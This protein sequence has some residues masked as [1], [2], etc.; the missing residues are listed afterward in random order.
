MKPEEKFLAE[1]IKNA[2][3]ANALGMHKFDPK[4]ETSHTQQFKYEDIQNMMLLKVSKS[5][6]A[7]AIM[8]AF[9]KNHSYKYITD[10]SFETGFLKD[11][12][13]MGIPKNERQKAVDSLATIVKELDFEAEADYGWNKQM[14]DL[15][16]VTTNAD[17]RKPKRDVPFN[18][19]ETIRNTEINAKYDEIK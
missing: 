2:L 6:Y 4:Q 5:P 12:M 14:D 19:D 15:A 13:A 3:D 17:N 11:M 18:N 16:D 10:S 8:A 9:S 7:T 1:A